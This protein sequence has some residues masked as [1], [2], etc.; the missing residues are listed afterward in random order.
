M[1]VFY[2]KVDINHVDTNYAEIKQ[3]SY[4]D[5]KFNFRLNNNYISTIF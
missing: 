4:N 5:N 2:Y 1:C 3:K